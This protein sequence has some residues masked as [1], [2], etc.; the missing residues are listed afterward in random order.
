[1]A[2]V[3]TER[4]LREVA[5]IAFSSVADAFDKHG[6]VRPLNQM[7]RATL[8]AISSIRTFPDG[9]REVRFSDKLAALEKI[10]RHLGLYDKDSARRRENIRVEVVLVG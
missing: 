10:G 7:S 1:V 8:A 6:N 5:A 2:E 9:S 3:T 4:W